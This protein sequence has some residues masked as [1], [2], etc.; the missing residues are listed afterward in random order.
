M[1]KDNVINT[2]NDNVEKLKKELLFY[3]NIANN[4]LSAEIIRDQSGEIKFINNSAEFITGYSKEE[5]INEIRIKHLVHPDDFE[6]A[7]K[8]LDVIFNARVPINNF[9][10]RII[11][12]TK[13]VKHICLSAIPLFEDDN[14]IG[15][16]ESIRDITE[17]IDLKENIS[18]LKKLDKEL[19]QQNSLFKDLNKEYKE[20]IDALQQSKVNSESNEY[21]LLQSQQELQEAKEKAVEADKLKTA[22]LHN[23]SHEIRT[24]MNAIVGFSEMIKLPDITEDSRHKYADFIINNSKQLLTIVNDILIMST[25]ETKQE[26]IDETKICLN[27][28]LSELTQTYDSNNQNK[29][30]TISLGKDF[31]NDIVTSLF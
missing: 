21:K 19:E 13:V 11:T 16:H 20:T 10:F 27:E 30:V 14:F 8:K 3:K 29:E 15:I 9:I 5:L 12:K 23:L 17:S 22:F 4:A 28:Y 18:Q 24:P 7:T 25:L 2:K 1:Q 6:N 26:I 31:D